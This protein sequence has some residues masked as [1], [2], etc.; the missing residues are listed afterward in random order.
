M[1]TKNFLTF[2][3]FCWIAFFAYWAIKAPSAKKT[4]ERQS[5]SQRFIVTASLVLSFIILEGAVPVAALNI[6]LIPE[7]AAWGIIGCVVC[8]VGLAVAI[9][10]RYTLGT[11]WSGIVTFKENHEL[12][13]NGPY[14]Y[15]RHPIYTGLL[16]MIIGTG[17]VFGRANGLVAFV[18]CLAGFWYKL[19]IEEKLMTKHFPDTYP[20]YKKKVKAL[21]PFV[22]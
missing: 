9:W 19:S 20:A 4:V 7:T 3:L 13:T 12:I 18:V 6:R 14:A 15:V 17:L 11:N 5:L 16:L 2:L 8:A 1:D 21:I 10:A 22:L